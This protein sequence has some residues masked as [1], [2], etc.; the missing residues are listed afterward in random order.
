MSHALD[1]CGPQGGGKR[2]EAAR[3]SLWRN[4]AHSA[5]ALKAEALKERPV[6]RECSPAFITWHA[7]RRRRPRAGAFSAPQARPATASG[8][9]T[10]G[11]RHAPNRHSPKS[12][13]PIWRSP[14]IN[15]RRD[16]A[17]PGEKRARAL[18]T[19]ARWG[20]GKR[21][22]RGTIGR[23]AVRGCKKNMPRL[24]RA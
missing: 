5:I 3:P 4:G 13:T 19:R 22:L 9:E 15:R 1:Y 20:L 10:G 14:D 8:G 21:R 11:R 2:G 17:T 6:R 23:A 18:K 16:G 12:P 7:D 24:N